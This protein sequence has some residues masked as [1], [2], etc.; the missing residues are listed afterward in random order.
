MIAKDFKSFSKPLIFPLFICCVEIL[1][2]GC[3]AL[4]SLFLSDGFGQLILIS[5]VLSEITAV[6][7]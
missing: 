6:E 1:L 7:V 3:G 4:I 2:H 5:L